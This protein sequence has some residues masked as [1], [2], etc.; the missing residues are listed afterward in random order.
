MTDEKTSLLLSEAQSPLASLLGKLSREHGEFLLQSLECMIKREELPKVP[1]E[2]E[3]IIQGFNT[4][5][6][7]RQADKI[8]QH[9][10]SYSQS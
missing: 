9:N 3:I 6:K 4:K 5:R 7:N 2:V 10:P 8:S 1:K